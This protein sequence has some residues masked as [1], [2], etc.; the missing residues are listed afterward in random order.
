M[1]QIRRHYPCKKCGKVNSNQSVVN[2]FSVRSGEIPDGFFC[3]DECVEL[4]KQRNP[5][6]REE[7]R[8]K[9]E[10]HWS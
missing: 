5:N 3:S 8:L 7:K 9:P 4:E 1:S 10:E 2:G 6:W